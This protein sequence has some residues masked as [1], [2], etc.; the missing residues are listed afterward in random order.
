MTAR[1]RITERDVAILESLEA[2]GYL[3]VRS[4]EW[5][6]FPQTW[7]RRQA[8]QRDRVPS[9]N[10]Y[11]RLKALTD[12]GYIGKLHRTVQFGGPDYHREYD[13]YYL[14]A[15]GSEIIALVRGCDLDDLLVLRPR[16]RSVLTLAHGVE[17]GDFYAALH[18][19]IAQVPGLRVSD[20]RSEHHLTRAYDR[21]PARVPN[22]RGGIETRQLAVQPDG[23]FLLHDARG[24]MRCF[25]EIDRGR[26]SVRTWAEKIYAYAAYRHS[27]T[28][29]ARYGTDTFLVL[30]VVPTETQKLKLMKAT[31][32]VVGHGDSR[33]LFGVQASVAPDTI[34]QGWWRV[35]EIKPTAQPLRPMIQVAPHA[36]WTGPFRTSPADT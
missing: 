16:Q 25:V 28:L 11:R 14:T 18:A 27:P 33:Y 8:Q 1:I 2:A 34:G 3:T 30:T 15:Q 10:V 6:H 24:A 5:L 13:A 21:V 29:Q 35:T 20:W 26:R 7:Q 9:P 31:A 19:S 4:I 23:T 32:G 36:L 17:V 22:Q 12:H